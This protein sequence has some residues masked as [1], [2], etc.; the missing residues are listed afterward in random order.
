MERTFSWSPH[1]SFREVGGKAEH[2][3]AE[4]RWALGGV[5]YLARNAKGSELGAHV[6]IV[7]GDS[8]G[9]P[10]HDFI[11]ENINR[12]R[13]VTCFGFLPSMIQYTLGKR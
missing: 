13:M 9:R 10:I 7:H 6:K 8:S 11:M 1:F 12:K 5:K 2:G 4:A 3:E